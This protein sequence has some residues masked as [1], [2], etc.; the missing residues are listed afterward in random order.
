MIIENV[1]ALRNQV[2]V[3]RATLSKIEKQLAKIQVVKSSGL[4]LTSQQEDALIGEI[5]AVQYNL[6][7]IE[8]RRIFAATAPE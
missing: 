1:S 3:E 6:D 2:A 5:S 4:T 8:T 7:D